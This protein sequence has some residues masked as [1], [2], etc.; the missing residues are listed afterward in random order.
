M[1]VQ[2]AG[3]RTGSHS[4][5][6]S[7]GDL[8]GQQSVRHERGKTSAVILRCLVVCL[9]VIW[10]LQ[11]SLAKIAG[12]DV[13]AT[14]AGLLLMHIFL[15]TVFTAFQVTRGQWFM[16][17]QREI[18]FYAVS[19][20][21]VNIAPLWL[22][23]TIAPHMSA[24]LLTLIS[25]MSPIMTVA[26]VLLVRAEQVT[27]QRLLGVV[28]GASAVIVVLVPKASIGDTGFG[29][30]MLAFVLPA[31]MAAYGVF[32]KHAWP[33]GRTPLQVST[34]ILIAGTVMLL[35]VHFATSALPL[36]DIRS[37]YTS[38]PLLMLAMSI[39]VEFYLFAL[40]IRLGGAVIASCADYVAVLAG[41]GWGFIL[42]G[43]RP[44]AGLWLAVG[45]GFMALWLICRQRRT[46]S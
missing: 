43:E 14:S 42:F 41:L 4:T 44:D 7:R 23:L 20:V 12:E 26:F 21:L 2:P 13:G 29:W 37:Q 30:T 1:T 33:R 40:L 46:A 9:G 22:E 35:P 19:A 5:I 17:C 27:W 8:S 39:G 18:G 11:I 3:N 6:Q 31:L 16:P 25:C 36:E 34:G 24:G 10:G 15:A 32:M 45:L 38:V 28:V